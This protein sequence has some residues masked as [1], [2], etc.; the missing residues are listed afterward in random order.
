M[1]ALPDVLL[2]RHGLAY[3]NT[4]GVIASAT[5]RGLTPRGR[6]QAVRLA[7]RLAHERTNGDVTGFHT[8]PVR[9]AH[10]TAT[11]IGEAGGSAVEVFEPEHVP[12]IGVGFPEQPGCDWPHMRG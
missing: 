7:H 6:A 3:C 4:A 11:V 2:I 12:A 1:I 10:E 8:S 5:C 9:R